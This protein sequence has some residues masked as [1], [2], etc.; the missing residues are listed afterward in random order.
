[1]NI[2]I[3]GASVAGPTLAFWLRRYGFQVTVVER[4]PGGLRPGGQAIDVRGT[5]LTVLELMG[6]RDAAYAQRTDMRGMTMI[7]ADG[8]EI[9]RS[10]ERTLTGG[11]IDSPDI[12]ILRDDLAQLITE[13]TDGVEYIFGDSISELSEHA[14]G[15]TVSFESGLQ[16]EF[17]LVIGA[18]GL[19]SRTRA[20][21]FG[22]EQDFLH[23][24]DTQIGIF[25]IPNILQ[26]D[27][28]QII[29]QVG[30]SEDSAGSMCIFYSARNNQ[31]IRAMLG[32]R[33]ELPADFDYRDAAQQ[34]AL[35]RAEFAR[36]AWRIPEILD[37]MDAAE[38]FHF[39]L[40][41]Q[42][43]M[44]NWHRGRVALV[45]DAAYSA[46]P[47]SGQGTSIALVG[48]YVL[49]GE[50]ALS[51]GSPDAYQAY[52]QELRSWVQQNQQLAFSN[53]AAY[54]DPSEVQEPSEF[55]TSN[56]A[57][58]AKAYRLKDYPAL[59]AAAQRLIARS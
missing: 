56:V 25:S 13:A 42:I 36:D 18:D 32:Y 10:E 50:L 30:P 44:D 33:G 2:L 55:P 59:L 22:A 54:Q 52:Q 5:A 47:L 37:A 45:G 53:S 3:S 23:S 43:K 26:L 12:E 51:H 34:K 39:D 6:L 17:T 41:A 38:D 29:R 40:M 31:A 7:G 49:A 9:M 19:H 21:A 8:E 57:E 11:L 35:L 14:D 58:V 16:R 24:L 1:M 4:H 28:W 20:L 46:S 27:H 15:V 48:A